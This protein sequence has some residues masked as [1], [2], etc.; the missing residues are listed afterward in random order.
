MIININN[1]YFYYENNFGI[2]NDYYQY[3]VNILIKILN[4]INANINITLCNNNYDF[5]NDNK[6]IRININWEHTIVKKGGRSIPYGTL[7]SIILDDNN[8][9][10]LIRIDRFNLLVPD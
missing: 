9:Y 7:D 8:E 10:Y 2:I 4:N 1:S 6:T 5:N 3:I